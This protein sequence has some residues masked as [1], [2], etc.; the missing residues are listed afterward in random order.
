MAQFPENTNSESCPINRL[1]T[2]TLTYEAGAHRLLGKHVSGQDSYS[3]AVTLKVPS[4]AGSLALKEVLAASALLE[5]GLWYIYIARASLF[6]RC[7]ARILKDELKVRLYEPSR[8]RCAA[9]CL[10]ESPL[11]VIYIV[12]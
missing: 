8:E 10:R 9:V 12:G 6:P 11:R 5:L 3:T 2:H 4:V 1:T 7:P